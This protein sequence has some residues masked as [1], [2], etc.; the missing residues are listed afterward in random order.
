MFKS[1]K[2]MGDDKIK[3]RWENDE[4]Y[5]YRIKTG[6]IFAKVAKIL[7]SMSEIKDLANFDIQKV[8]KQ[9]DDMVEELD[10]LI[11]PKRYFKVS[12]FLFN[13]ID[14]YHK[15]SKILVEAS[16]L[17]VMKKQAQDLIFIASRAIREGN[18][19]IEIIKIKIVEVTEQA[20]IEYIKSQ[21]K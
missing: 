16:K 18:A 11:V 5:K 19:W 10:K 6:L 9:F 15:S 8:K 2:I 3:M 12:E 21:E 14:A 4:E 13:C 1:K 20:T 17:D 7:D